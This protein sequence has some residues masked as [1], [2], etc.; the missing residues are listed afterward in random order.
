MH[1]SAARQLALVP[2]VD[3]CAVSPLVV[4]FSKVIAGAGAPPDRDLGSDMTQR[5]GI[6][7]RLWWRQGDSKRGNRVREWGEL[8]SVGSM[9]VGNSVC[10]CVYGA[11]CVSSW[12]VSVCVCVSGVLRRLGYQR[13]AEGFLQPISHACLSIAPVGAC[14]GCRHL[15]ALPTGRRVFEGFCW[16]RCASGQ[17]FRL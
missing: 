4:E 13:P 2:D 11:W 16:R 17:G 9:G 8:F 5:T 7:T 3:A 14:S 12:C 6:L 1:V 10:V 15:C